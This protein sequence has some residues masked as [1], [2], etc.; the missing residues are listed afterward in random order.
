MNGVLDPDL[1]GGTQP[2][3]GL[4]TGWALRSLPTQAILGLYD[5]MFLLFILAK[6]LPNHCHVQN[7]VI[8]PNKSV[9]V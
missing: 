4:G 8:I 5:S 9:T 6:K 3:A 1:L 2:M 7:S